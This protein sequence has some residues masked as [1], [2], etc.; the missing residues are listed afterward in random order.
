MWT[1]KSFAEEE[2]QIRV[3][4][5]GWIRWKLLPRSIV[6]W[7]NYP[8]IKYGWKERTDHTKLFSD[9]DIHAIADMDTQHK[10]VLAL[11]INT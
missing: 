9:C 10:G 2:I 6:T 5:A 3:G 1:E 8:E 11:I 7:L 4:M